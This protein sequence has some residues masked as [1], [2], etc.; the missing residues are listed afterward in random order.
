MDKQR[1]LGPIREPIVDGIFYPAEQEQLRREIRRLLSESTTPPGDA[2]VI[3][4]PHASLSYCGGC[5]AAAYRS[6]SGR[7]VRRVLLLGP[8][9]RDPDPAL[10][11]PESGGFSTPLGTIPVIDMLKTVNIS[12][13]L[14]LVK[15]DIPHLEEHC[16]EIQLPF[17]QYLFPEAGIIPVLVGDEGPVCYQAVQDL[18]AEL[19]RGGTEDLLTVVSV[20]LTSTVDL[21]RARQE[22]G[23]VVDALLSQDEAELLA[24]AEDGTLSARGLVTLA[25][26]AESHRES[27]RVELVCR[28]SSATQQDDPTS[29]VEYGSFAFFPRSGF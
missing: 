14:P 19:R 11:V 7:P 13:N 24:G 10:I 17:I 15:R 1:D 12:R 23:S 20:N 16:L 29:T 26:V 21:R 4:A 25:A 5:L 18:I 8:V 27:H 22:A 6:A 2:D 28:E 3:V 9:Y